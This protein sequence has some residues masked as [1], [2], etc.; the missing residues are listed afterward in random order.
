[1]KTGDEIEIHGHCLSN[2]LDDPTTQPVDAVSVLS[3]ADQTRPCTNFIHGIKAK[4]K[5]TSWIT[6]A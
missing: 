1:M 4:T 3:H 6:T 5:E 2:D